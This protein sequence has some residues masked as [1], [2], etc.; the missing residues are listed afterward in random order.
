M[1][2]I[3]RYT[4]GRELNILELYICELLDL[5]VQFYPLQ[6][7]YAETCTCLYLTGAMT[8]IK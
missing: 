4:D 6:C 2:Q 7:L 3:L 1:Y 8:F 5:P